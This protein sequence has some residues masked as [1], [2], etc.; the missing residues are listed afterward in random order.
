LLEAVYLIWMP[1]SA[2]HTIP[3]PT[4]HLCRDLPATHQSEFCV[5]FTFQTDHPR[6]IS[7]GYVAG[8]SGFSTGRETF[9]YPLSYHVTEYH[10]SGSPQGS[11]D[12]PFVTYPCTSNMPGR[13]TEWLS[14]R[15]GKAVP[16]RVKY[17]SEPS[18][19]RLEFTSQAEFGISLR[20]R[21]CNPSATA[22]AWDRSRDTSIVPSPNAYRRQGCKHPSSLLPP[23][24]ICSL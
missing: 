3:L 21:R 15:R 14:S 11:F 13:Q 24:W 20:C 5:F 2:S 17:E 18:C 4:H 23:V 7:C 16:Y 12:V 1:A 8:F 10:V 9:A 19:L 6:E 22:S